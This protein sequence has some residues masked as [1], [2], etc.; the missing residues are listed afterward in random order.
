M[1]SSSYFEFTLCSS[2]FASVGK[3]IFLCGG[4]SRSNTVF[5]DVVQSYSTSTGL[6]KLE[7][8]LP[9][10]LHNCAAAGYKNTLYVSGGLEVDRAGPSSRL[11]SLNLG[12]MLPYL[13]R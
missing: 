2:G 10:A 11:H 13:T 3:K 12:N 4:T 6:W 8:P 1:F 7:N 9:S 5:V